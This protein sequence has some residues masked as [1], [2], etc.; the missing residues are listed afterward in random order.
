M[1]F[2]EVRK[3]LRCDVRQTFVILLFYFSKVFK[4]KEEM[5][6]AVLEIAT[7]I[8]SKSPLAVQGTKNNLN[9]SRDHSIPDS[10]E[11]AVSSKPNVIGINIKA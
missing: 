9:Y 3:L 7:T 4:N 8:A 1:R 2:S 5:I 10:L 11:Y 6:A